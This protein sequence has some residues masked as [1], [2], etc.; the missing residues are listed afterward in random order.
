MTGALEGLTP[1]GLGLDYFSP[2]T[3]YVAFAALGLFFVAVWLMSPQANPPVSQVD[4]TN[5][6]R[7]TPIRS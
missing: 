3:G 5:T 2:V 1:G 6:E 7:S 4:T